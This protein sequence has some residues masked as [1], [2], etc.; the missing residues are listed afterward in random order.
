MARANRFPSITLTGEGG[1]LTYSVKALTEHNPFYWAATGSITQPL[2]AFGSLKSAETV[3][4]EEYRQALLAYEQTM[5][6][7]LADVE[8]A[9]IAIDTYRTESM[10][11]QTLLKAE[12]RVQQMTEALYADGLSSYLNVIDAERS[13]YSS[14][15]EYIGVLT[16]QL[17]AYVSLYKALGGG[18]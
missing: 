14:Q 2:F 15:L 7:A 8:S 18:W 3:A 4:V 10:R 5:L 6:E 17:S 16:E 13:L 1:L 9:L 12:Q 11:Y